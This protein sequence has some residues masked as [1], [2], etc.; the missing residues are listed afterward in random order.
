VID[1]NRAVVLLASCIWSS[2]G[3][4][5]HSGENDPN[6]PA[7]DDSKKAAAALDHEQWTQ[8]FLGFR[9]GVGL[10]A[11]MGI[12]PPRFETVSLGQGGTVS[13][14]ADLTDDA[15][16]VLETH[17]AFKLR[18]E[19]ESVSVGPFAMINA[20]PSGGLTMLGVGPMVN[21]RS[22]SQSY[23]TFNLGLAYT[24]HRKAKTLREGIVPNLKVPPGTTESELLSVR[25]LR[26]WS[27][28]VSFSPRNP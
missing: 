24:L 26:S 11:S 3:I 28:V 13:V 12:G 25:T 23:S 27:V 22:S 4:T 7:A 10:A 6:G 16:V 20:D 21:F 1:G 14:G 19:W 8:D 2:F 9:W 5:A 18:K 17:V 15:I